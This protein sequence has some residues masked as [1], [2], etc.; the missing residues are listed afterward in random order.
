VAKQ[1]ESAVDDNAA[2]LW[3]LDCEGALNSAWCGSGTEAQQTITI[4]R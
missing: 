4:E 1:N 3:S 2:N